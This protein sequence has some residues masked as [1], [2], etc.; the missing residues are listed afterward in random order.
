ML[1]PTSP[2][3]IFSDSCPTGCPNAARLNLLTSMMRYY[4]CDTCHRH[5]H[6][7]R[8][9]VTEPLNTPVVVVAG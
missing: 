4:V 1:D 8:L 7:A 9:D 6:V 5:W 2:A 3:P